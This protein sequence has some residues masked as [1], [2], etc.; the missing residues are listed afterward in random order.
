MNFLLSSDFLKLPDSKEWSHTA[1]YTYTSTTPGAKI[2][3]GVNGTPRV[4]QR[5][6]P[7]MLSSPVRDKFVGCAGEESLLTQKTALLPS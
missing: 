7:D 5:G 4:V 1:T 6:V 3:H 2:V